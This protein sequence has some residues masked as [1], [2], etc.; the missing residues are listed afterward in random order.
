VELINSSSPFDRVPVLKL[1]PRWLPVALEAVSRADGTRADAVAKWLQ[2]FPGYGEKLVVRALIVPTLTRLHFIR[3]RPDEVEV[4]PNGRLWS[5]L[6]PAARAPFVGLCLRDQLV[7]R[8]GLSESDASAAGLRQEARRRGTKRGDGLLGFARLAEAYPPPQSSGVGPALWLEVR[9]GR[10]ERESMQETLPPL[11]RL[12]SAAIAGRDV[13]GLDE[14]RR[15]VLLA[16]EKIGRIVTSFLLD[17]VL[18]DYMSSGQLCS[19]FASATN[20][21]GSLV[22]GRTPFSAVRPRSLT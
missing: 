1:P 4:A 6:A 16:L 17:R 15:R 14:L 21:I 11:G 20:Q 10:A 19:P 2:A 13:V 9:T 18:L 8:S 12:L 5:V 22:L 7:I 3:V